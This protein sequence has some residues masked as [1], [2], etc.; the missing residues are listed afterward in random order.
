[1]SWLAGW[2]KRIKLTIDNTN[3]DDTLT[4][5]PVLIKIS[6]SSGISSTDVT[7]IFT[8]LGF[9]ANRKKITVTTSDE[10]TQC[11][12]EIECWDDVNEQAELWTKIPTVV[13]GTET[14][15]Y[16]YYDSTQSDNTSYVGDTTDTI[17]HNVWDDNFKLV[18]HMAQ[19]PNGDVANAIKDSTSNQND[20]TP[21][22]SMTSADLV[23]GQI[24]KALDF[25]GNDDGATCGI[26]NVLNITGD[27]TLSM[28]VYLTR[29]TQR[30]SLLARQFYVTSTNQGGYCLDFRG[31]QAGNKLRFLV[32]DNNVNSADWNDPALNTWHHIVGVK[33]GTT[34]KLYSDNDLKAT[35]PGIGIADSSDTVLTISTNFPLDGIM[36]EVR[37]SN[38]ARSEAWIK[39]AYYNDLDELVSFGA[40]EEKS[41]HISGY[42]TEN[43]TPVN[44][45]IYLHNRDTGELV[46]ETTSSGVGGYFYATTTYSGAHYVVCIDDLAGLDYNDLIYGR[47]Y[48]TT[49]SG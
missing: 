13:S 17:T 18:M 23:D 40:A 12:V 44:R 5:F 33:S 28:H 42:V 10:T 3:V 38:T 7:S 6:D 31:D 24:G 8:E 49:T 20:G 43:T 25:D 36:D 37:I 11:Y 15:L 4:D 21:T 22:G 41:Y 2:S 35:T 19:D 30:E 32:R 16:L 46:S 14:V 39:A 34:I 48:P 9:D 29:N 26:N 47:V 27:L 45:Q 1:M